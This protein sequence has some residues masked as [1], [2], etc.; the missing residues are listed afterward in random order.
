MYVFLK[1]HVALPGEFEF[2]M[3]HIYTIVMFVL[4]DRMYRMYR[5]DSD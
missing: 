3:Y 4:L 1:R 2:V 5:M